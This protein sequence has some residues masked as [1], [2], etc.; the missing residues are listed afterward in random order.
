[1]NQNQYDLIVKAIGFAMPALAE[2]LIKAL[3]TT[4]M[5]AN[6]YSNEQKA[7]AETK[8]ENEVGGEK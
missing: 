8:H 3:N 6:E 1:M 5:L 7:T 4:V 2:E